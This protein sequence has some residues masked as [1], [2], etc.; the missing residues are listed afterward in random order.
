MVQ[1]IRSLQSNE[2]VVVAVVGSAGDRR[3][4]FRLL[5]QICPQISSQGHTGRGAI[6]SASLPDTRVR[7]SAAPSACLI[8]PCGRPVGMDH[9]VKPG[10]DELYGRLSAAKPTRLDRGEGVGTALRAFAPHYAR[11]CHLPPEIT[12]KSDTTRDSIN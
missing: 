8:R 4:H 7:P 2:A 5:D 3:G 9:R 6:L 1:Q 12:F 10:G 11:L